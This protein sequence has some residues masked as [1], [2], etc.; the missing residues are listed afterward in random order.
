MPH[1]PQLL[2]LDDN[3]AVRRQVPLQQLLADAHLALQAPQFSLV[4]YAVAGLT[5]TELQHSKPDWQT[6]PH[7][8]QLERSAAR[9]VHPAETGCSSSSSSSSSSS[10]VGLSAL[11]RL[12]AGTRNCSADGPEILI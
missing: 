9:L 3:E 6:L 1:F 11:S 7:D 12:G 5:H 8:P 4:L 10:R 2:T